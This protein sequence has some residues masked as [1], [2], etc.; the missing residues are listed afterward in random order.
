MDDVYKNKVLM[1]AVYAG[2]IMMESG[3]EIHR[4]EDTVE[5]ICI[6]CGMQATEVFSTPMGLFISLNSGDMEAPTYTYIKRVRGQITDMTKISR[7][8]RFSRNFTANEYTIDE[9]LARLEAIGKGRQY[10]LPVKLGGA[11]MIGLF[12]SFIFGGNLTEATIAFFA[13]GLSYALSAYLNRYQ[14]NYFIHGFLCC[15]FAAIIAM[16]ASSVI[17]GADY[18]PIIT[19]TIMIFVPGVPITNSIRD[20]LSGDMLSGLSRLTEAVLTATS[21]ALGAGIVTQVWQMLGGVIV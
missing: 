19:G 3:A 1:M 20:F 11:A 12:F 5:R 21:I 8:N 17:P 15:A 9:A 14:I 7:I 6:A 13:G 10:P 2:E 4:V 18:T 16:G